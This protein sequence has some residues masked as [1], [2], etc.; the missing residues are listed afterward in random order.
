M[1]HSRRGFIG[2]TAIGL[3]VGLGGRAAAQ[4]SRILRD[5]ARVEPV[6]PSRPSPELARFLGT[7]EPR[8]VARHASLTVLWLAG[9]GPAS[10]IRTSTLDE[11]R[12]AGVLEIR[13]QDRANVPTLVVENRGDTHVLML[14]GE[15]LLGGKQDR[16][17]MEDVL[18]PP[19]SG[20]RS[21]SVYCVEAGRWQ[22]AS[23]NFDT[24]AMVAA[25]A[26]RSQVM[27]RAPQARV[28]AE[29][30][31]YTRSAPSAAAP[32]PPTGSSYRSALEHPEVRRQLQETERAPELH[33]APATRGAA[34]FIG[35][36]FGGIDAFEDTALFGRE[37]PKLLRAY[38]VDASRAPADSAGEPEALRERVRQL[39][40]RVAKTSSAERRNAGVGHLFEF[41]AD[42]A[43]GSALVLEDRVIHLALL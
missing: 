2:F 19:K 28:W 9:Q 43:R 21:V 26:L 14:A 22:G 7:L 16:V 37:W 5:D 6:G 1:D 11:A 40:G 30:D 4:P 39:L 10:A 38:A 20:A 18:L 23:R 12:A 17:V 36:R 8:D 3:A 42:T 29:V 27:Q 25:P 13:E 31:R 32:A 15:I 35:A 33:A 24:K 34:V 41:Q